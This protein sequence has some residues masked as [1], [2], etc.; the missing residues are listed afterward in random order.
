MAR[1]RRYL[2]KWFSS[3]RICKNS[4][5]DELRDRH[6][7]IM[8]GHCARSLVRTATVRFSLVYTATVWF[9]CH[10]LAWG[11]CYCVDEMSRVGVRL[12]RTNE[13]LN[14]QMP[15]E[16]SHAR[17][18]TSKQYHLGHCFGILSRFLSV[19]LTGIFFFHTCSCRGW[20]QR[21]ALALRFQD[22]TVWQIPWCTWQKFM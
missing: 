5:P 10:V 17:N 11:L 13:V 4:R 20:F 1:F 21:F 18:Y 2:R 8:Y 15:R 12:V 16:K 14:L 9:W 6:L 3:Y 22:F 19:N 7:W